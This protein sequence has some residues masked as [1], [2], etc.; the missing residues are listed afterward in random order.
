MAVGGIA[1]PLEKN[2]TRPEVGRERSAAILKSVVLP[3]PF[4]PTSA[5][6]SPAAIASETSRSANN[7]P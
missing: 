4:G 2:C 6:H 1:N 3:D 5:T 7:T